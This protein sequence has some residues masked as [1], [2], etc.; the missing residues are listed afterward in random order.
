M[1]YLSLFSGIE[2]VSVAWRDLGYEP[3]AFAEIEPFCCELLSQRFPDIPD[4]GDIETITESDIRALGPIDLV[5]FGS[6]CQDL[7]VA[8]KREGLSG[9]R[10]GLF[11]SAIRI[12]HWANTN[13]GCR[14]ALWENVPGTFSSNQGADFSD[15]LRLFTGIEYPVPE[16]GWQTSGAAVGP[17]ALCE[18]RILDA[19]YFGVP[20]RRRRLFAF[21]DFGNWSGREPVL[22]EST[23]VYR[24]F[25][26]GR[27]A[28][29]ELAGPLEARTTSGGFPG[30]DG[31]CANHIVPVPYDMQR[32]GLYGTGHKA[33]S[34]KQR[35]YKDA[36]DLVVIPIHDQ[37]TVRRLTP[38][39]CERL[40][41]LPDNWTQIA[42]RNKPADQCPSTPRYKCIG[43]SMAVP[44][45][46]WL[47][48][49]ILLE[50]ARE[51]S[52]K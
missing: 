3:V 32:M 39:E 5:V 41:G 49:Q 27:K 4:F 44:V 46:R 33:S 24:D 15:V 40:Q 43:N 25:K 11:K 1:K 21:V 51:W 42:W 22:F 26:K 13:N 14:F 18:W 12:I 50:V 19:Q 23:G 9:E 7:S 2:A 34:L 17:D 48:E 31:A 47:G 8:G 6:P 36:T 20:Q 16:K 29:E 45:I 38:I 52:C 37:A 35:D 30:T 10:S 28:R